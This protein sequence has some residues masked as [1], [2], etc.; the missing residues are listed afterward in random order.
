MKTEY[1]G[2]INKKKHETV[3]IVEDF[4]LT[5]KDAVLFDDFP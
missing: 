2:R 5:V 3:W 4:L 1:G